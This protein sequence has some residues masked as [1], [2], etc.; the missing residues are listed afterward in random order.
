M[1]GTLSKNASGQKAGFTS[2]TWDLNLPGKL[3]SEVSHPLSHLCD[4]QYCRDFA[5]HAH[6]RNT[7]PLATI[8]VYGLPDENELVTCEKEPVG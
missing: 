1:K 6:P 3:P 5:R 2:F 8:D 4:C 7:S